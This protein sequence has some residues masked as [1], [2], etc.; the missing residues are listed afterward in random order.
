MNL[1]IEKILEST[2]KKLEPINELNKAAEDKQH[3]ISCNE[4]SKERIKKIP[5]TTVSEIKYL[6]INLTKEIQIYTLKTI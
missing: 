6:R 4:W 2:K 5:F 1:Y 3:K